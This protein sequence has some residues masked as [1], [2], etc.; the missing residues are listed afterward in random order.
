MKNTQVSLPSIRLHP[1]SSTIKPERSTAI[2]DLFVELVEILE[3][4]K[5]SP[6]AIS[7]D[8]SVERWEDKE[9]V[10]LQAD[11]EAVFESEIDINVHDGQFYVR[12]AR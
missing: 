11:L 9:F 4:L 3:K 1:D 7:E 8:G 12:L 5:Q 10:Y 2:Q 6:R